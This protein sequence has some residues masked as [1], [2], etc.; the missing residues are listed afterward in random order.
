MNRKLNVQFNRVA[1]TSFIICF[2]A[3]VWLGALTH[4]Q[5]PLI[6]LLL[7]GMYL[8][9]S[10]KVI[11]QWE[12]VALLRLGHYVGLR[13]PGIFFIFPVLETLSPFVDQRVRVT[14]VT[15]ESTLSRDTVPVDVDAI[16]FWLVWNAEKAIL[17]VE[18][19]LDAISL[20]AQTALRES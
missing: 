11:S 12:K 7:T 19:Y 2:A 13:G 15:A 4:R 6:V 5:W 3:G 18:N 8:L 1:V 16:I 17:E 14:S 10:I 20:S 9:Y